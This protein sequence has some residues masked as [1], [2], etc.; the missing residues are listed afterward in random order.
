MVFNKKINGS[1]HVNIIQWIKNKEKAGVRIMKIK[2]IWGLVIAFVFTA[3]I[4][5]CLLTGIS[6]VF[7]LLGTLSLALVIL[8]L[9]GVDFT[10]AFTWIFEAVKSIHSIYWV[11]L[12]IG[13][14]V[15]IWIASGIV[16]TLVFFGFDIVGK[17]NFLLFS[18]LIS[19]VVA[20]FLGT[21]LG[22]L[23]TIGVALFSLGSSVGIPLPIL[24]GALL[25]GAYVAD[26]LSPI[27]ALVNFTTAT[28]QVP[29]KDYFKRTALWMLPAF[30]IALL[31]YGFLG[32]SISQ[33]I[34]EAEI[35]VY[36]QDLLDNFVIS[37]WFLI[38]PAVVLVTSFKGLGT[39]KVLTVGVLMGV[40]IA[41]FIQG[42]ALL[43]VLLQALSGFK[44]NAQ[45]TFIQSLQIGGAL[46]M[47]EVV[48]IIMGGVSMSKIYD[49]CGWI[50]PIAELVQK[51][52]QTR[53]RLY[54]KTGLLSTALNALT[55]DQTVGIIIPGKYLKE[56]YREAGAE[57]L[58]LAQ[59]IANSGT[60]L[61]PL[62]P[63]N[64]N[65]MIILAITG[66]GAVSYAP[67]AILCWSTFPMLVVIEKIREKIDKN[68]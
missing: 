8:K 6:L 48:F 26:R 58:D 14:N 50:S 36:R 24:T 41:V 43:S 31:F 60:S 65:A 42:E 46:G 27:S 59:T 22:T 51:E 21:G 62:M 1:F 5:S 16:P 28:I 30:F 40:G 38:V 9:H 34:S 32:S 66:V 23:S 47:A 15:S 20:F 17:V 12:M 68:T 7:G 49:E 45:S 57:E 55:C 2:P 37:P 11:V 52:G 29:F 33:T 53:S 10:T 3:S 44:T 35:L 18:F 4:I 54:F 63:W 39:M 56:A 13:I 61:A 64:V 25:S 67:Y 19:S